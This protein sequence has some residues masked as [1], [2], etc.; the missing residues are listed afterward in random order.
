MSLSKRLLNLYYTTTQI[1]N[2]KILLFDYL[3]YLIVNLIK[4]NTKFEA[5]TLSFKKNR[6]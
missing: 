4:V 2:K 6:I 1:F 5:L 3:S